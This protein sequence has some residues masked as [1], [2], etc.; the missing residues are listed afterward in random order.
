MKR[1]K[2]EE[3]EKEICPQSYD[4]LCGNI[5]NRAASG[6]L[7]PVKASK[8]NGKKPA[9]YLE[10]WIIEPEAGSRADY[11][12]YEE[13]LK[14]GLS[15]K[16][17]ADYY[18]RHLEQ[19]QK[20][21]EWVQML[22]RYLLQ[23]Q[24]A[25]EWISRNERSFQIWNREKFLQAGQGKTILKRC[26][27]DVSQ[28]SFYETCEPFAYYSSHR[29]TPQNLLA[30]ENK[31][32]FYSMR[33]HLMDGGE[34]IFGCPFGTLVY[35]AGKGILRSFQEFSICAEPYM[36]APENRIYYFGDLDY[37]GIGI[38]ERLAEI[39][40]KQEHNIQ[41]FTQAYEKMLEKAAQTAGLPVT[42]EKQNRRLSGRFFA[43]FSQQT[44]RRMKDVLEREQYIPQEILNIADFR[45]NQPDT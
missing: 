4:E 1:I 44:V 3:I 43:C 13:E 34:T 14:Y 45:K 36:Q 33:R 20:D 9:L 15:T 22:N 17:S 30:V 7:K 2:L 8:T 5:Y 18:L 16:I 35:G 19:Y 38:Y 26:G 39:F 28:L 11:S 41:P 42:K 31:D 29:R 12:L 25:A 24:G 21:R 6:S 37:E 10:Y 23:E 27:M 40:E 32:T